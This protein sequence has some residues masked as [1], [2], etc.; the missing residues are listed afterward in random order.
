MFSVRC[1]LAGNKSR[2]FRVK[3]AVIIVA[4]ITSLMVLFID[5]GVTKEQSRRLPER[6]VNLVYRFTV[7]KIPEKAKR[8]MAWIPIPP[9]NPQ[10][11]LEGFSLEGNWLYTILTETEYG[12]QFIH[13]DLSQAVLENGNDLSVI[14]TFRVKR[15]S[16][17]PLEQM[18]EV[19]PISQAYLTRFLAPDRLVPIDGIIAAEARRVAGGAKTPIAQAKLLYSHIVDSITYNKTGKGWGRGDALF[20][21]NSRAGNCTDFHSLFIGEARALGIPARFLMGLL[22]PEGKNEG[23]IPGYHCWAEFYVKGKGWIPIDAAEASKS[24]QKREALFGRLDV[25][26]V[27]F[28]IGRDIKLPRASIAPLNYVIYPHIE[29]NGQPYTKVKTAF[30]FYE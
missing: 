7:Q 9:S 24:S 25:N 14:I 17:P 6:T 13:L 11:H 28:T 23:E 12:N 20:V 5:K 27:E 21:C 22:L 10:Q 1:G 29:L 3:I 15:K 18:R 19:K 30:Y 8:I 16:Y 4:G 2:I 26:R